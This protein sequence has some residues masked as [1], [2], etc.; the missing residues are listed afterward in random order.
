MGL[1]CGLRAKASTKRG[2]RNSAPADRSNTS[3]DGDTGSTAE[4]INTEQEASP[5][6]TDQAGGGECKRNR[7]EIAPTLRAGV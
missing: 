5:Q 6:A 1:E 3:A 4:D 7:H 2:N